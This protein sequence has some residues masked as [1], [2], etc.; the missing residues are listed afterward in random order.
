ML[1]QP[2]TERDVKLSEEGKMH[3]LSTS[4][5]NIISI[6]NDKFPL[7]SKEWE[8]HSRHEKFYYVHG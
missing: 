3:G 8:N 7:K 2:I 1:Y 5:F 6:S 4:E